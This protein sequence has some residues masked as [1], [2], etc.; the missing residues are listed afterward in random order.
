M[1]FAISAKREDAT[2]KKLATVSFAVLLAACATGPSGQ[3]SSALSTMAD[4]AG[5]TRAITSG[6]AGAIAHAIDDGEIQLAQLALTKASSADVRN[7]AQM[8]IADHT[9]ANQQL[10][11]NGYPM[12]K[13][14]ATDVLTAQTQ[15]TLQDLQQRSGDDFDRAYMGSQVFMHEMALRTMKD[16]IVP[17]A[18]QKLR[19]IVTN[20]RDQ[21]QMHLDTAR[22]LQRHL[23][24]Y[25]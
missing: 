25:L 6:D 7:F 11:T 8:M 20:M 23:G 2:M 10:D 17:S 18:D 14:P 15:R 13:N 9:A 22:S 24:G 16:T 12:A 21:V 19:P 1:S 3:M 5:Q 4:Q